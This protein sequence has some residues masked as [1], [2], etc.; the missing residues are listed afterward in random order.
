MWCSSFLHPPSPKPKEAASPPQRGELTPTCVP[1]GVLCAAHA[2]EDRPPGP[3]H[4]CCHHAAKHRSF[5]QYPPCFRTP[6]Q[7]LLVGGGQILHN[8]C[9][10]VSHTAQELRAA[11]SQPRVR[12]VPVQTSTVVLC[13]AHGCGGSQHRAA[14]GARCPRSPSD[15]RA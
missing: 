11:S 7:A 14:P 3:T 6:G 5:S 9:Q 1:Y 12:Q 10:K 8:F 13:P 2:S 15:H 4:T